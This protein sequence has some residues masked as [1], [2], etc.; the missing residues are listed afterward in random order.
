M[1]PK[2]IYDKTWLASLSKDKKQELQITK[3]RFEWMRIL[4]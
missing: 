3:E 1:K 4:S 2:S